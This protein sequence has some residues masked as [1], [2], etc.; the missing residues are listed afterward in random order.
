MEEVALVNCCLP[1]QFVK[2]L[3]P[4]QGIL[5]IATWLYSEG[6]KVALFDTAVDMSPLNFAPNDLYKYLSKISEKIIGI[7]V[8]DSV[9][10]KIIVATEKLKKEQPDK[11]IILGGP[12]ASNLKMEI[13]ENF[14]W[15]D[16]IV[17]GEGEVALSN[18]LNWI[19]SEKY[20]INLLS[21]S[22]VGRFNGKI[23][24]G[25]KI[26]QILDLKKSKTPDYTLIKNKNY[27][28]AEIITTRGCPY[29][30]SFCSVNNIWGNSV[31]FRAGN[32][33]LNEIITL[34]NSTDTDC[35]H[36]LDDNFGIDKTRLINFCKKFP[37][38]LPLKKWS[39]Y[40]R[41]ND[42]D[43]KTVDLMADSGCCGI[44]V[45]IESGAS[46]KLNEFRKEISIHEIINS[47]KYIS[48]KMKITAS[49]IWGFPSEGDN[50]FL[51]TLKLI[52][53]ILDFENV[54]INF[55][56]LA[57]LSGT[58][59]T[60]ELKNKLC[61]NEN[62]ISGFVY[63]YFISPLVDDEKFLIKKFPEI[64]SAFYHEDC[65]EFYDKFYAVKKFM[66]D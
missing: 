54:Y 27:N 57:P 33:I 34:F 35:I 44:Y 7:S 48:S 53:R 24:K 13:I 52:D 66:G 6:R 61:F 19:E 64:F 11:I 25:K 22:V 65:P 37:K 20:D 4:P 15:I 62:F 28:R 47:V 56:Q 8:W 10:P 5:N 32:H 55:Y 12:S 39:C 63:P 38:L 43:K 17:S 26:Q 59:V 18:L 30:C 29:N 9:I 50:Q 3:G 31:R 45:G 1:T 40:F 60:K 14:P 36:I 2:N 51:S 23:I 42:L 16:Y 46:G 41:L 58:K 49:F 21:E